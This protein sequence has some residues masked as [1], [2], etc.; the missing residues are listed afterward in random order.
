MK[1]II[2][3]SLLLLSSA[4]FA[5]N[6]LSKE[7]NINPDT[8]NLKEFLLEDVCCTRAAFVMIVHNDVYYSGSASIVACI[9]MLREGY[10]ATREQACRD[11]YNTALMV[12]TKNVRDQI[13]AAGN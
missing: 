3:L 10:E 4:I 6:G 8:K 12:A 5:S 2:T 11:A 9:D 13:A 1:K 7:D